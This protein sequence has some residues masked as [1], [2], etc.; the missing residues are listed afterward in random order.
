[1][2]KIL[3]MNRYVKKYKLLNTIDNSIPAAQKQ[4]K[5]IYLQNRNFWYYAIIIL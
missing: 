5:Y 4:N 1:M 3:K 2:W